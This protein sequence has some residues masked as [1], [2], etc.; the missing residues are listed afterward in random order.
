[1]TFSFYKKHNMS[2]QPNKSL[3][4]F[5]CDFT[6]KIFGLANSEFESTTLSIIRKHIPE[7][8]ETAFTFRPSKDEKYLAITATVYIQSK[9]Q[10]DATYKELSSNPLVLMVL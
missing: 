9:E 5:P 10:L 7:L 8:K 6:L 3:L 2:D 4:K 1:M